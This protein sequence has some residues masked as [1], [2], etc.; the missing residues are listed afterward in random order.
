MLSIKAVDI[1]GNEVDLG[2]P[3]KATL[4]KDVDVP[5][6]SVELSISGT[7]ISKLK[8]LELYKDGALVFSGEVD[9]QIEEISQSPH[10]E[11]VARSSAARLIDSEAYPMSFI[12]PSAEDIFKH[13]AKPLGFTALFGENKE[14][15]GRFTVAKGTSCFAVIKRFAQ[16]VYKSMPR[17]EGDAIYID[18]I[19]KTD[20]IIFGG[21]GVAFESLRVADLRCNLVSKVLIK[22]KDGEGYTKAVVNSK[23]E[24]EGINRTRYL[25]ATLGSS[26]SLADADRIL[27][28]AENKSF[29]AEV[30]C[31]GFFGDALGKSAEVFGLDEELYVSA[32]RYTLEKNGEY[33]KLTL[34]RKE[35]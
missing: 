15:P 25:N 26:S 10:T 6:D 19:R 4:C 18:G 32:L 29:Y 30:L 28:D 14:Y 2:S 23:A 1:L 11:L 27:A 5:A 8:I 3:L 24:A 35:K 16:E 31:R 33:T 12:N 13:C 22:L 21:E 9:E 7:C 17:C 20:K 34:K